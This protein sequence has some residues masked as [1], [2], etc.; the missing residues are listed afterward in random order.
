MTLVRKTRGDTTVRL[1]ECPF[2]KADLR[3]KCP[4]THLERCEEFYLQNGVEL[5]T[6]L[7]AERV[8][9]RRRVR[10]WRADG[11]GDVSRLR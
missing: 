9:D 3:D 5:P 10:H 6:W 4:P 11:R 2:C 7:R 8:A 1:V